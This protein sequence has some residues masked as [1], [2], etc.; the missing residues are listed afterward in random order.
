MKP[1]GGRL[2]DWL[3]YQQRT[4]PSAIAL[5]LERVREVWQ[6]LGAPRPAPL[7]IT[8][9][10]TNGKGS[11]VAFLEAML[12]AAGRRVGSYT[13]PHL[14]HYTERVRIDGVPVDEARLVDA[15]ERIEAARGSGDA[16]VG[17][18]YFE[19]GTLAALVVFAEAGLDV[20]VLEVGLGGR[21]D[22][23]NL[24]DADAAIVTTVD[25][26]HQ[27]W[28]GD[29]RDSI[30]R[31]KAGIF[32]AGRPA[33]VGEADPPRGLLEAAA[34]TGAD[35]RRAG[36]DFSMRPAGDGWRWSSGDT[37]LDLPPLR[38]AAPC[39]PANAGAAL[40][41]LHALRDRLGWQAAAWAEGAVHAQAAARLQR[42]GGEVELVVDVAHN[43][44]A[45]AM[46]GEWLRGTPGQGRTVAV[47]GALADKD[48]AGVLAPLRGLIGHWHL[49]G[50]DRHSPRG[51][52]GPALAAI[53]GAVEAQVHADP[54]DALAA[55]FGAARPGDRILA[56]GSFFV[57]AAALEYAQSAGLTAR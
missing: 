33:I 31:E 15:F 24:I 28:L 45:A 21:L 29:D 7:V 17:L 50:L 40:A 19:F 55:A 26:D 12:R 1:A 4:H 36:R 11:T 51:L 20:A 18:T 13:S 49:A 32:R 54:A 37:V 47:Y 48:V 5:G 23:V 39:Q 56:F 34:A 8:V 30:G 52:N 53:V 35:L 9:G 57:A 38:L 3:D 46:L 16:T 42:F 22:A 2:Q 27:D 25:L 44:Q 14:L 43:P 6:R 41:A 10:G